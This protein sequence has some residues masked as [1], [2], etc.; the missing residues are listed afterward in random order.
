MNAVILMTLLAVTA[1]EYASEINTHIK[2]APLVRA[3]AHDSAIIQHH[4]LG[5][6]FAYSTHE[7][8][9]YAQ[10]TPIIGHRRVPVG[11]TYHQGEPIVHSTTNYVTAQV[12]RVG[13]A[14]PNYA[15]NN[16]GYQA[17][18]PAYGYNQ[19]T[20]YGNQIAAPVYSNSVS[21]PAYGYGVST[22]Y[23]N[24][25]AI[26]AYGRGVTTSYGHEVAVPTYGQGVSTSYGHEVAIPAYGRGVT[27]SYGHEVAVP[28]YGGGLAGNDYDFH[29]D[30]AAPIYSPNNAYSHSTQSY[31]PVYNHNTV[32]K[33]HTIVKDHNRDS[34][35][36][37]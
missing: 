2:A 30:N 32:S 28:A 29:Y 16:Y 13:Y 10:Q 26:P 27:T 9:A 15:T 1:A 34:Y 12:P 7:R 22:S 24:E 5:G 20:V 23:G 33:S 17:A 25:V 31:A 19:A 37:H 3:P 14:Y 21:V 8:P 18:V 36:Y 35:G 11:V 4:R 6:N